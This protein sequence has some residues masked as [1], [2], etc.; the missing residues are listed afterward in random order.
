MNPAPNSSDGSPPTRPAARPDQLGLLRPA[1]PGQRSP[2]QLRSTPVD[3]LLEIRLGLALPGQL[4][5]HLG[6]FL[7]AGALTGVARVGEIARPPIVRVDGAEPDQL[8]AEGLGSD[9]LTITGFPSG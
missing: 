8:V 5:V 2:T 3:A 7:G 1:A 4:P 6:A 9:I